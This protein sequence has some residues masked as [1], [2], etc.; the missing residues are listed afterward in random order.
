MG[1]RR[2]PP[3]GGRNMDERKRLDELKGLLSEIDH[4]ILRTV[5]RRARVAQEMT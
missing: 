3:S 1:A 4:E 5:E 2:E